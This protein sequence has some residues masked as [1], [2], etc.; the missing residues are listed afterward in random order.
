MTKNHNPFDSHVVKMIKDRDLKLY[1]II[2]YSQIYALLVIINVWY[3]V[4]WL[5]G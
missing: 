4:R 1:F 3:K 2:A 5:L